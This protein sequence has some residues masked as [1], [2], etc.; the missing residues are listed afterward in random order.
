MATA[1]TEKVKQK[2][3]MTVVFLI[4]ENFKDKI[5][6]KNLWVFIKEKISPSTGF[7]QTEKKHFAFAQITLSMNILATI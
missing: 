5:N 3:Y 6:V 4:F 1:I 7:N 2:V